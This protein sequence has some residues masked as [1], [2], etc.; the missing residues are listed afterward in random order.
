V[1]AGEALP[2]GRPTEVV[3][4]VQVVPVQI[5]A[6]GLYIDTMDVAVTA[7]RADLSR[8]L[9][10]VRDGEEVV[11][12]DRGTP[13][14]RLVPVDTTPLL[15]RLV[16]QGVVSRPSRPGRPAARSADR[17]HARGPVADLVDEQRR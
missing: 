2:D 14:A 6:D 13:V 1:T 8:W 7:L 16:Q 17:V 5:D 15:D 12:T 4:P 10:R 3:V 9:D 11:V